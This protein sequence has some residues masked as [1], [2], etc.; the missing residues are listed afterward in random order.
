MVR[1]VKVEVDPIIHHDIIPFEVEMNYHCS[2]SRT[3]TH[4][5]LKFDHTSQQ[6]APSA[7]RAYL[8]GGMRDSFLC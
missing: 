6:M 1:G 3:F 7:S 2:P 5:E 8:A 4:D